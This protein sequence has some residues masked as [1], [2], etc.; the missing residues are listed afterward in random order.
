MRDTAEILGVPVDIISHSGALDALEQFMGEGGFHLV[1][2]PNPEMIMSAQKDARIKEILRSAALSL[3]DGVGV[4]MAS[5]LT[6]KPIPRRVTGCDLMPDLLGRMS[7]SGRTAY[8]LGGRPGVAEQAKMNMEARYPGIKIIGARHGYFTEDYDKLISE[9]LAAKKPDLLM[10]G[11]SY[12][13]ALNWAYDHRYLN[14]PV[15][16][17]VGGT[18]DI[19]SGVVTRAPAA[20]RKLGLEWFYRLCSQPSRAFRMLQLPVFAAM[21]ARERLARRSRI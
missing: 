7:K 6:D 10:L 21:V 20:F 9:D 19:L 2:T 3:P 12:E 16:A 15:V 13:L 18:L 1:V 11:L 8:F 4:V 17:C 14:I 5:R